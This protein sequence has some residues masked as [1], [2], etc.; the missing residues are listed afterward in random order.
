ME[1]KDLNPPLYMRISNGRSTICFKKNPSPP[2][3]ALTSLLKKSVDHN[4][5]DL[6]LDL[7]IMSY[8]PICVFLSGHQII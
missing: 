3:T 5:K 4:Y 1:G 2:L 6:F 7:L 8:W